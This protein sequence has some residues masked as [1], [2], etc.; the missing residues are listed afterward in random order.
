MHKAPIISI[1]VPVY[2]VEKYI[3]KCID[4]LL[5]QGL[6]PEEY[7]IILIND[8]STDDSLS[9][10]LKYAS[11]YPNIRV[12]SQPNKGPG[13]ARN[14][15]LDIAQ[16]EYI[17]IV[18]GDDYLIPNG[19]SF[20]CKHF[21]NQ[22]DCDLIIFNTTI[23]E[24]YTDSGNPKGEITYKGFAL[25]LMLKTNMTQ[26][27][28]YCFLCKRGFLNENALRFPNYIVNEDFLFSASLLLLNPSVLRLSCNFY[29]YFRHKGSI[30]TTREKQH[31]RRCVN[32]YIKFTENIYE[33][34]GR[35]QLK[36]RNIILFHQYLK[37]LNS[38]TL[39]IY[40]KLLCAEYETKEYKNVVNKL[41]SLH[42]L[43]MKSIGNNFKGRISSLLINSLMHIPLLYKPTCS[44]YNKIFV[45]CILPLIH[46]NNL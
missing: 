15:G 31:N 3:A 33:L 27:A 46:K 42:L 36:E 1:I 9:I 22:H 45:K 26:R 14:Q 37:M 13:I 24:E 20:I 6:E 29:R 25:D 12:E 43:P 18:D 17:Y 21:I 16:G 7:E 32:D 35:Y 2:N 4:S 11:L 23:V 44:F 5:Q 34:L 39:Y 30:C 40:K 38:Q 19:L 28:V 10:C 41:K 8:G